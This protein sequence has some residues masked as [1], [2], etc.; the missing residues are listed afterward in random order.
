MKQQLIAPAYNVTIF[1]AGDYDTHCETARMFCDAHGLCVTVTRTN[2]VY[3]RGEE[4][5][6]IVGLINYARFPTGPDEIEAKALALAKLL[7]VEAEQQSFTIQ[8]P[9]ESRFYSWRDAAK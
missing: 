5:G 3:T 9:T 1:I 6:V 8:T 4:P 2:Y 7:R